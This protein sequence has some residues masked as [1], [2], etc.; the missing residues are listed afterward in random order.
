MSSQ[1]LEPYVKTNKN[2]DHDAEG[3]C[4]VL[5]RPTMRFVPIMSVEGD[6]GHRICIVFKR[7]NLETKGNL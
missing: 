5:S 1:Y 7:G 3:I 2:D 6:P 4:E